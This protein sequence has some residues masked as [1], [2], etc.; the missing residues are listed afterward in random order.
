MGK[1]HSKP[2]EA[3]GSLK[4]GNPGSLLIEL[5]LILGL[6]LLFLHWALSEKWT[7]DEHL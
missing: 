2:L 6:T 3:A 4:H 7:Q 1:K 5:C